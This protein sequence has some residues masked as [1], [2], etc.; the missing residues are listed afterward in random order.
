MTLANSHVDPHSHLRVWP[1]LLCPPSTEIWRLKELLSAQQGLG[2]TVPTL[3]RV[4]TSSSCSALG[5]TVST[6]LHSG[7][8][9]L[10]SVSLS[11]W[12][13]MQPGP[14]SFQPAEPQQSHLSLLYTSILPTGCKFEA[15]PT[16]PMGLIAVRESNPRSPTFKYSLV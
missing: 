12:H 16:L 7:L 8:Q 10:P 5:R 15:R 1:L 2:S 9:A 11:P 4:R 14:S 3:R 6:F 13:S